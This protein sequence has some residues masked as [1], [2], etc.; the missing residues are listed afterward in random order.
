M[1]KPNVFS[2][3]EYKIVQAFE[4]DTLSL[5]ESSPYLP[6]VNDLHFTWSRAK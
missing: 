2:F 4:R 3:T 6:S 5:N 1:Q